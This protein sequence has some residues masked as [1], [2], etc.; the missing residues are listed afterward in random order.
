M[1][2]YELTRGIVAKIWK[3]KTTKKTKRQLK[4][5]KWSRKLGGSPPHPPPPPLS[6]SWCLNSVT[7]WE[8]V[9]FVM[10]GWGWLT[11]MHFFFS[12]DDKNQTG[13]LR[14]PLFKDFQT[15]LW[16]AALL[17]E[18]QIQ[19]CSAWNFVWQKLSLSNV[20]WQVMTEKWHKQRS[21]VGKVGQS[22]KNCHN[23]HYTHEMQGCLPL[24]YYSST[25]VSFN[26]FYFHQCWIWKCFFF[27]FFLFSSTDQNQY[28]KSCC[29]CSAGAK[30]K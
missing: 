22:S 26:T 10:W 23:Y 24:L 17:K 16:S 21:L 1:H 4:L 2:I 15:F 13:Q 14:T 20:V 9:Y 18:S 25:V 5:Q 6:L 8:R 3:K 29:F 19:I 12:C 28:F 11:A 27:F 30:V 7:T